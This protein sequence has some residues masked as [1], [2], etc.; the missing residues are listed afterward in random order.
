MNRKFYSQCPSSNAALISASLQI[1]NPDPIS[2]VHTQRGGP[3][4]ALQQQDPKCQ[5]ASLG[6]CS[7]TL[8]GVHLTEARSAWSSGIW[9]GAVPSSPVGTEASTDAGLHVSGAAYPSDTRPLSLLPFPSA[10]RIQPGQGIPGT[11]P[12]MPSAGHL[13]SSLEWPQGGWP[14]PLR[15]SLASHLPRPLDST[16]S[17][18][19]SPERKVALTMTENPYTG[20]PHF[21][22]RPRTAFSGD[23]R[24]LKTEIPGL[25][26]GLLIGAPLAGYRRGPPWRSTLPDAGA[27][28]S[29]EPGVPQ[30]SL[31]WERAP[32]SAPSNPGHRARS[33]L[34]IGERQ[35]QAA[36][37]GT[38]QQLEPVS[39]HLHL[40]VGGARWAARGEARSSRREE[41]RESGSGGSSSR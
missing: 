30:V 39:Q 23:V 4:L 33:P 25:P 37:H 36:S 32:E 27:R 20:S 22:R 3:F 12:R 11:G 7:S 38:C 18:K 8:H 41:R 24:Y 17:N 10:L 40:G 31:I 28:G 21:P 29:V 26:L 34:Q 15:F 13:I 5:E 1:P 19:L 35:W 14:Q 9:T 6:I 16:S 2:W